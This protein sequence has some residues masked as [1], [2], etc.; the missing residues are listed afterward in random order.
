LDPTTNLEKE[1]FEV[2]LAETGEEALKKVTEEAKK[3]GE[4]L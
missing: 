2:L 4:D 1:G 3:V